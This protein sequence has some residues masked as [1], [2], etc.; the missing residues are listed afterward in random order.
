MRKLARV[1]MTV[2]LAGFG[3]VGAS[4]GAEAACPSLELPYKNQD[5]PTASEYGFIY[6]DANG[7]THVNPA[8]GPAFL[9]AYASF[10]GTGNAS[11]L[12]CNAGPV[13]SCVLGAVGTL[14]PTEYVKV[15]GGELIIDRP[16]LENDL[17]NLLNDC[18][19]L[20]IEP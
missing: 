19:A 9:V 5:A 10:Y 17:D 18:P 7:A 12:A 20:A 1:M 4:P 3:L 8:K 6:T 2:A 15:Q 14:H 11:A 16:Q 13:T